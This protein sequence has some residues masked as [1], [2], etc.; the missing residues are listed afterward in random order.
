MSDREDPVPR[1]LARYGIP[2]VIILFYASAAVHFGFTPEGTFA[3]LLGALEAP[4]AAPG[5]LHVSP[6]WTGLLSA[7]ERTGLDPLLAGKVFGLLFASLAVLV[8]FLV[9]MEILRDRL[10]AM[11]VTLMS[12]VQVWLIQIGVSGLPWS[13]AMVLLLGAVFFLQRNEYLLSA[14]MTGLASLVLWE[15]VML[16]PLLAA[17]A[18]ANSADRARGRRTALK[19][20]GTACA[21]ALIWPVAALLTRSG[22]IAWMPPAGGIVP[23]GTTGIVVD[24]FCALAAVA[25][26]VVL[27]RSGS[28]ERRVLLAL[29]PAAGT[30]LL[31]GVLSLMEGRE[32]WRIGLPLLLACAI[33]GIRLVLDRFGRRSLVYPVA[34]LLAGATVIQNQLTLQ[35][36]GRASMAR[37]ETQTE[38]LSAIAVWLRSHIGSGVPVYSDRP[39]TL[40]WFAGRPTLALVSQELPVEAVVVAGPPPGPGFVPIYRLPASPEAPGTGYAVW[41]KE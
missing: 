6:L 21:I 36:E 33:F 37:T 2:A 18:L 22:P 28:G 5:P 8:S 40:S 25:G 1:A 15:A 4:G 10:L 17:D 14:L 41:R 12:A 24:G 35:G 30:L 38:E 31:L 32:L 9:A 27:A 11:M 34:F 7:A 3:A 13:A 19:T 26:W 16:V 23:A 39:A 20:A 29:L